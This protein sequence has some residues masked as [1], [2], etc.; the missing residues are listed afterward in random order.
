MNSSVAVP[1]AD[2]HHGKIAQRRIS[3][4]AFSGV[5]NSNDI[6]ADTA[7]VQR[8]QLHK[9]AMARLYAF[10]RRAHHDVTVRK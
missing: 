5:V 6:P 7:S 9:A 4:S 10:K 2:R 3:A 8:L 1:S